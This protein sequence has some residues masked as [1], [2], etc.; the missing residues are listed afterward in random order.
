VF[1]A[2]IWEKSMYMKNRNQTK[3]KRRKY[4]NRRNL[5]TNLHL[6]EDFGMEADARG[7]VDTIY[8]M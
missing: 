6:K 1:E 2:V 4:G 7:S 8:C 3:E 5:F